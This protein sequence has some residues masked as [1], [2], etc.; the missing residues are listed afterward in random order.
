MILLTDW[1]APDIER[2]DPVAA[3]GSII[4]NPSDERGRDA[5][6]F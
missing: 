2:T 6:E 5:P 4:F 3:A 1:L